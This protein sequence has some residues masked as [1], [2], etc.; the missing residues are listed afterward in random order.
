MSQGPKIPLTSYGFFTD[1][2]LKPVRESLIRIEA[3]FEHQAKDISRIDNLC[4]DMMKDISTLKADVEGLKS[5][6]KHAKEDVLQKL[7]IMIQNRKISLQDNQIKD[8]IAHFSA[9]L[10]D[11][12]DNPDKK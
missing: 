6:C 3:D 9:L 12:Q 5:E 8:L 1:A 7:I 4:N 11:K 2:F 10:S